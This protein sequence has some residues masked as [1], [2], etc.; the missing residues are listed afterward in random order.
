MRGDAIRRSRMVAEYG[1]V[2]KAAAR[3]MEVAD[4]N[5]E[6]AVVTELGVASVT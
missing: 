1:R 5:D 4:H 6:R 3:P 2:M